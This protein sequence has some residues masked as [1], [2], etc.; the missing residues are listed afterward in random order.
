MKKVALSELKENLSRYL[1]EAEKDEVIITRR[2]KPVAKLVGPGAGT[3]RSKA[4]AAVQRILALRKGV[5]L[6]DGITLKDL[7]DEGRR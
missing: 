7:I 3:D 6:G 4:H 1:Y 2:G 5:S